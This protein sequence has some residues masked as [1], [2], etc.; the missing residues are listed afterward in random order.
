MTNSTIQDVTLKVTGM[1]CG[2][3]E[4]NVKGK[5]SNITGVLSVDANN[6]EDSVNVEF[7]EASINLDEIKKVIGEAGFIVEDS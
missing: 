6:K 2:G 7:N 3:C 1:K 4:T 5:L